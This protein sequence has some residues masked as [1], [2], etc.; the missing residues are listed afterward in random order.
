MK[1][2]N[3]RDRTGSRL[4][5]ATYG[6]LICKPDIKAVLSNTLSI[7]GLPQLSQTPH[8]HIPG[9]MGSSGEM[10]C[11]GQHSSKEPDQ[12]SQMGFYTILVTLHMTGTK[13]TLA[14]DKGPQHHFHM[15]PCLE[16][17][18]SPKREDSDLNRVP[19]ASNQRWHFH[20]APRVT[21]SLW[22]D[23]WQGQ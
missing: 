4:Q 8:G 11:H 2:I 3:T 20:K 19:R 21:C 17:F 5:F 18:V 12:H 16:T 15:I 10:L 6:D 7:Q 1:H 22:P 14:N 13:T 23:T 9:S